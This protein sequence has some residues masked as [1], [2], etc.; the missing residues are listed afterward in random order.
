MWSTTSTILSHHQIWWTPANWSSNQLVSTQHHTGGRDQEAW[1]DDTFMPHQLIEFDL[2]RINHALVIHR[3]KIFP[4][5]FVLP[6]IKVMLSVDF[7]SDCWLA[8]LRIE[9]KRYSIYYPGKSRM[10]FWEKPKRRLK[11]PRSRNKSR[12]KRR[13]GEKKVG[14]K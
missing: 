3:K 9:Q 4:W 6:W 11:K 12:T 8:I 10:L 13:E 14:N 1:N 2:P 7:C 5:R